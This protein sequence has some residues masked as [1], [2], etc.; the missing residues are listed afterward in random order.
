[1]CRWSKSELKNKKIIARVN[2]LES[3]IPTPDYAIYLDVTPENLQKR[4]K[5]RGNTD[6]DETEKRSQEMRY[7][8][9][10]LTQVWE[11]IVKE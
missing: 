5:S 8:Y 4:L 9:E 11:F 3:K 6:I 1:M 2:F 7:A 10:F